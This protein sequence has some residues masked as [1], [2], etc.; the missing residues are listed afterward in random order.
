M[1]T[2]KSRISGVATRSRDLQGSLLTASE[3]P[4]TV[5]AHSPDSDTPYSSP[6]HDEDNNNLETSQT[7]NKLDSRSFNTEDEIRRLQN[8]ISRLS[9]QLHRSASPFTSQQQLFGSSGNSVVAPKLTVSD[10]PTFSGNDNED[11]D[12]WIEQINMIKD[13]N[14]CSDCEIMSLLPRVFLEKARSWLV[15]NK[16]FLTGEWTALQGILRKTYRCPNYEYNIRNKLLNRYYKYSETVS[17]Y[18]F[19]K[20]NL[21]RI[22]HG[23]GYPDNFVIQDI[24]QGL[25]H[26][27]WQIQA[28]SYVTSNT[29]L[30]DFRRFL[31]DIEADIKIEERKK[32]PLD[33]AN[34]RV[35]KDHIPKSIYNSRGDKFSQPP[36]N[37]CPNCG[38][39]HWG[40]FCTKI[41]SDSKIERKSVQQ[42]QHKNF[43]KI[44]DPIN[45]TSYITSTNIITL[46]NSIN[47][48]FE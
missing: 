2:S 47:Q 46:H 31:M 36:R 21:S 20:C 14:L 32:D 37:P 5:M 41:K 40:K 48:V 24:I 7:K 38:G 19:D 44:N 4:T 11:I 15:Q 22:V 18:V 6:L 10:L 8:E 28:K 16:H 3:T 12:E 17:Q 23:H 27:T 29:T 25:P 39:P 34:N 30:E 45:D 35:H 43:P 42:I 33:N 26:G 1:S 13:I 9:L